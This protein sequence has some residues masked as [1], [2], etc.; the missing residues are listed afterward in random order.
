MRCFQHTTQ[1]MH[2]Y[3]NKS[4]SISNYSNTLYHMTFHVMQCICIVLC[5][6][7]EGQQTLNTLRD[8]ENSAPRRKENTIAKL[9][10]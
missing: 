10:R 1:I 5:V 4:S 2:S 3:V 7:P 9:C 6:P 8:I